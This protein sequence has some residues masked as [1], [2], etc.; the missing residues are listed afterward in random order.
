MSSKTTKLNMNLFAENDIVDFNDINEN[1]TIIDNAFNWKKIGDADYY[2]GTQG[3]A[4]SIPENFS[5]LNVKVNINGAS[6]ANIICTLNVCKEDLYASGPQ[7][8]RAGY[9]LNVTKDQSGNLQVSGGC[10]DFAISQSSI[11]LSY[12]FLNGAQVTS[13]TTWSAYYR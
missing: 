9:F 11:N 10:A 6:G 12:A 4:I 13:N 1:T 5:E 2:T 3:S 7:S 8:F